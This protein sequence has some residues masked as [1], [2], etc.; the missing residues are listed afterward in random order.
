MTETM[1]L[2]AL[3]SAAAG[4]L[5]TAVVQMITKLIRLCKAAKQEELEDI[6]ADQR[7]KA[8]IRELMRRG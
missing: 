8:I 4:A 2:I 6:L 3:L 7:R 1:I 5:L